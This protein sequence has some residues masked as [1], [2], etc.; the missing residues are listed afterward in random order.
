MKFWKET[1]V[2]VETPFAAFPKA[3]TTATHA[4][5][6]TI[7]KAPRVTEGFDLP[8]KLNEVFPANDH[9]RAAHWR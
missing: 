7:S 9:P 8:G 3:L 6:K 5:A 2:P 4:N 1:R